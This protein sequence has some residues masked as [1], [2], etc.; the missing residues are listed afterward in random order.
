MNEPS[1]MMQVLGIALVFA[2]VWAMS[3]TW[4]LVVRVYEVVLF[5]VYDYKFTRKMA[6]LSIEDRE[7]LNEQEARIAAD[8]WGDWAL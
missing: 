8:N 6:K 3:W 7:W 5:F 2:I 4:P 1:V